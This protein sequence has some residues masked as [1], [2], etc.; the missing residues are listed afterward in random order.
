MRKVLIFF[1]LYLFANGAFA[2]E[3]IHTEQYV[4]HKW[5]EK[6]IFGSVNVSQAIQAFQNYPYADQLRKAPTIQ[7]P[8]F[9]TIS[10]ECSE[11][12]SVL[13]IWSLSPGNYEIYHR[14]PTGKQYTIEVSDTDYIVEVIEIYFS[15]DRE[16]LKVELENHKGVVIA[17]GFF[18]KM[19]SLFKKNA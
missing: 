1:V 3:Y 8:T 17:G 12:A 7:Q 5:D 11:D 9:P 16:K 4:D 13:A 2:M 15:N 19:M 14:S 18:K 10:F 6:K